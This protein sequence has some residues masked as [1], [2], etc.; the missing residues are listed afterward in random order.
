[1][2]TKPIAPIIE[3]G[4][5]YGQLT[6]I[7]YVNRIRVGTGYQTSPQ[8]LCRCSCGKEVVVARRHL[9]ANNTRSCGC[10]RALAVSKAVRTHGESNTQLYHTWRGMLGRCRQMSGKVYKY[11]GARDITV[12]PEWQHDYV[13]FA[14]WARENGYVEGLSLERK[15][16]DKGYSPENCKFITLEEQSHNRRCCISFE[17]EGETKILSEWA[18]DPR[19]LVSE[20]LLYIRIRKGEDPVEAML[21]PA[22]HMNTVGNESQFIGGQ[23]YVTTQSVLYLLGIG[24]NKLWRLKNKGLLHSFEHPMSSSRDLYS[25][26]EVVSVLDY[27]RQNKKEKEQE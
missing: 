12:Y 1:M 3:P 18:R 6:V 24:R 23:W 8:Y 4:T 20:S 25:L 14:K 7:N 19:C 15:D 9:V 11:Y 10:A 21:R 22:H 17:Y 5:V 2:S 27:M 26:A 13:A 16:N